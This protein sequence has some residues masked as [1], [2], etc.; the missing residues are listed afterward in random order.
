MALVLTRRRGSGFTI[1][2]PEAAGGSTKIHVFVSSVQGGQCQVAI[3]AARHVTI[4]RDEL[5]EES[6]ISPS[7]CDRHG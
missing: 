7:R 2:V 3:N 1:E 6:S 4:V 5:L